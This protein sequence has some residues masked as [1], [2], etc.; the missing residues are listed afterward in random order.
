MTIDQWGAIG[1][2]I[3]SKRMGINTQKNR[4]R[5]AEKRTEKTC[6]DGVDGVE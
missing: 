2:A 4:R 3:R 6:V 1:V 5:D